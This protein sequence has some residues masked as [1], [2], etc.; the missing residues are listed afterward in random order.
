MIGG[1]F[2]RGVSGGE[3]KR[4]AIA[5]MMVTSASV[6]AWDSPTRGL[7]ASTA[8]DYVRSIR[9]LCN[10]HHTS[11]FIT[12]YQVSESIYREFD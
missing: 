10:I 5:E 8:V 11:T 12:G 7:D 4:A 3:R 1:A 2:V 6:C 9:V